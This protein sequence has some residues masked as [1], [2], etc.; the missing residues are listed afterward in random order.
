MYYGAHSSADSLSFLV[1]LHQLCASQN[2]CER[3]KQLLVKVSQSCEQEVERLK[4]KH[5][6]TVESTHQKHSEKVKLMQEQL[7]KK[8][9]FL[10]EHRQF[11]RVSHYRVSLIVG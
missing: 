5:A 1:K 3:K 8:E 2:E 4:Q 7:R 10:N 6:E 9:S 11:I